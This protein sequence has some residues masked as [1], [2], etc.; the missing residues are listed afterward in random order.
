M[1]RP[2]FLWQT[3]SRADRLLAFILRGQDPE[4]DRPGT[5]EPIALD[6]Y[7]SLSGKQRHDL[8]IHLKRTEAYSHSF[9]GKSPNT[10]DLKKIAKNELRRLSPLAG[11]PELVLARQAQDG[12]GMIEFLHIRE[13]LIDRIEVQSGALGLAGFELVPEGSGHAWRPPSF[14][15]AHARETRLMAASIACLV[16][17]V[18]IFLAGAGAWLDRANASALKRESEV[19]AALMEREAA[20]RETGALGFIASLR[21]EFRTP[22]SRLSAL[23]TLTD[24]TPA[25][26][27]W[28][29]VELDGDSIRVSGYSQNAAGTLAALAGAYPDRVVRFEQPVSPRPDGTESFLISLEW[30]AR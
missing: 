14:A 30:K 27:W 19:R 22:A 25:G 20:E 26:A 2:G 3:P 9:D 6:D 29:A 13:S 23:A 10:A 28:S 15:A 24:N 4:Q 12:S 18:F 7:L 17:S 21:P 11:E 1:T 5:A 8:R 16:A